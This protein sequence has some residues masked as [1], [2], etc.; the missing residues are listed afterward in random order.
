MKLLGPAVTAAQA[1][2]WHAGESVC[3]QKQGSLFQHPAEVEP[4]KHIQ[5]LIPTFAGDAGQ[6]D[7]LLVNDQ[8]PQ[9]FS[10]WNEKRRRAEFW[11]DTCKVPKGK[12]PCLCKRTLS[13]AA[14]AA[15]A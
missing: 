14:T 10:L 7:V 9:I 3:L 12:L 8:A 4:L 11:N 13:S 2:W 5:G 6:V 15:V 1:K